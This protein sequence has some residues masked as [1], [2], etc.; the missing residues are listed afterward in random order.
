MENSEVGDNKIHLGKCRWVLNFD[1]G[2]QGSSLGCMEVQG[3][4]HGA[5]KRLELGVCWERLK[6]IIIVNYWALMYVRP[7]SKCSTCIDS[8]NPHNNFEYIW[9]PFNSEET[10]AQK[11]IK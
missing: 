6:C 8:F 5:E 2:R 1:M 7:C 11:R 3:P 10:E 4:V 9:F